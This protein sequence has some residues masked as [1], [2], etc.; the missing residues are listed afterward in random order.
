VIAAISLELSKVGKPPEIHFGW[1]D[2]NPLAANL[3]FVLFGEGNVPYANNT[4]YYYYAAVTYYRMNDTANALSYLEKSITLNSNYAPG[5]CLTAKIKADMGDYPA[6]IDNYTKALSVSRSGL[7][8]SVLNT[9]RGRVYLKINDTENAMEDFESSIK[10]NPKDTMAYLGRGEI[11]AGKGKDSLAFLDFNKVLSLDKD[12]IRA[13][14]YRGTTFKNMGQ[15]DVA[16]QDLSRAVEL[17]PKDTTTLFSLG[18]LYLE[19]EKFQD[20]IRYYDKAL[21]A[22]PNFKRVYQNRGISY[23]NLGFYRQAMSDFDNAMKYDASLIDKLKPLYNDAK[24]R[25]GM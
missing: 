18:N 9:E 13:L 15:Y 4:D 19:Q 23:Y 8:T 10:L 24:V 16:M 25:S 5:Y 14:V 6:A 11:Y 22:D 17:A 7:I 2:E 3:R 21:N 1:S 20:A 12:N